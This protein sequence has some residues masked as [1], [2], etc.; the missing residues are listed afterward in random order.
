MCFCSS[1]CGIVV[2]LSSAS[3]WWRRLRGLSKLPNGHDWWWQ[4][5]DLALVVRAGLSKVL[6]QLSADGRG[7]VPSLFDLRPNYGGDNEDHGDL[8]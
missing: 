3:I 4:K 5:L 8:L 2:L 6:I 1:C 7:C